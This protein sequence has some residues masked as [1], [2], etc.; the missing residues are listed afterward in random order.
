MTL[1]SCED[2]P[3]SFLSVSL[4]TITEKKGKQ[5]TSTKILAEYISL[6]P[7]QRDKLLEHLNTLAAA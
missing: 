4:T 1:F 3:E 2:D 7:D 6:T 5:E